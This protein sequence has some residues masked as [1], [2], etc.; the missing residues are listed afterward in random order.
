M[1][2]L[3]QWLGFHKKYIVYYNHRPVELQELPRHRK[4]R[5]HEFAGSYLIMEL[6]WNETLPSWAKG[7][8]CE[9]LIKYHKE[10][11]HTW[12]LEWHK[13]MQ[14]NDVWQETDNNDIIVESKDIVN[15]Y[16]GMKFYSAY[17]Q[18]NNS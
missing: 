12:N 8:T 5:E 2:R 14:E 4:L 1:R 18:I 10:C 17:K 16:D 15:V 13:T 11:W 7:K 6:I 9:Y 3:R